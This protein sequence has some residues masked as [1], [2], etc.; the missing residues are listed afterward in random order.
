MIACFVS[1]AD[2]LRVLVRVLCVAARNVLRRGPD[3]E[4]VIVLLMQL[5]K[6][7]GGPGEH[8]SKT[9]DPNPGLQPMPPPP[10]HH[11]TETL[12]P[13]RDDSRDTM[14]SKTSLRSL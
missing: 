10:P 7:D 12:Q 6:T 5:P 2:E 14:L 11:G 9:A 13:P 1:T 4:V 3:R 8:K